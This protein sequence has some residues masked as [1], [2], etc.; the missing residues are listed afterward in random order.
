MKP[1]EEAARRARRSP[2]PGNQPSRTAKIWI[3]IR[4]SQKLGML[5]PASR[6]PLKTWSI[7]LPRHTA[8][9]DAAGTPISAA[10]A[11]EN[12]VEEEGRL[13]ALGERLV[14][15][16]C[17]KIDWPRLPR[18]ELLR[19]RARTARAAACRARRRRAAARCRSA[20]AWSPSITAA[21]S[22]GARRVMKN[23]IVATS[24]IT[25]MHAGEPGEVMRIM[26]SASVQASGA[27]TPPPD[28]AVGIWA[29]TSVS[30]DV[31]EERATA[32]A[33]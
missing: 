5:A 25:T 24:N 11:I 31:P 32:S 16:R 1:L 9:D 27:I 3:R 21:G 12:S 22:P 8:D 26:T 33:S 19:A 6:A 18:S 13:G 28:D 2:R 14:T 4:P 15:G 7:A 17:R 10:I 20:V 29:A 23:T 30:L